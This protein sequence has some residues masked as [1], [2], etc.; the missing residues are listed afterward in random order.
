[1]INQALQYLTQ[2]KSIIP[3]GQDKR[4]LIVWKDYQTRLATQ[5]EV[6]QWWIQWPDA[7]IGIVTGK[8]SDLA[9]VDIEKGGSTQNMP[10]TLIAKTGGGGWHYYYKYCEGVE[11]KARVLPLTDIRGE[12]GFVVAPPS[13]HNSGNK[14][15]WS[16]IEKPA[17]FPKELFDLKEKTDWDKVISGVSSGN[18]NETAAKVTGKLLNVFKKEAD[19]AWK[20]L[21]QWNRSNNPPLE[22]EELRNVFDS[23]AK[24]DQK[25]HKEID[26]NFVSFT[27]VLQRGAEELDNTDPSQIVSFGYD[28][29]DDKLTG[30][31]PGELIVVGGE[32]GTGK[33]TFATNIIYKASRKHKAAVFALEDRLTDYGIKALYFE[34]GR[35][36]KD[37]GDW[38]NYPWNAYRKNEITDSGYKETR[39][40]A[41]KNLSNENIFFADVPEMMT[42]DKL[43]ELIEKKQQEGINLFLIDH[44]HYFDFQKKEDSKADYIEQ[45][46]VRLK[47]LQRKTGVQIILVVHYRKLNGKKPSLDSFKDSISI[48]QNA[49]YVINLWRDREESDD[50]QR[51]TQFLVPKAR[52]PNGEATFTV[53]FD[54]TVND[55]KLKDTAYGTPQEDPMGDIQF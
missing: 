43:E 22:E 32:T 19:I 3:V 45:I 4:P 51:E 47:T 54:K 35:I 26:V 33:T 12:G 14:Y 2:G 44:L 36:R 9:V 46:M 6:Q 40:R 30:I 23:I 18:R 7:N 38:N 13:V 52:N 49:N 28:W 21:T 50:P 15:E 37:N 42:I 24:K 48:V 16:W 17:E 11:N 5:E 31:F 55:Y 25:N 1:M 20:I 41:L 39:E 8:L 29:L 53:T 10:I 34:M 27:D